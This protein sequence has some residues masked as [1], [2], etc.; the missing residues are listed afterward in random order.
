[1]RAEFELTAFEL[2][3]LIRAHI[4]SLETLA[5]IIGQEPIISVQVLGLVRRD[6]MR[7]VEISTLLDGE[8]Q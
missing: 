7:I 5:E 8:L 3:A 1:M 4:K 6:A 2:S